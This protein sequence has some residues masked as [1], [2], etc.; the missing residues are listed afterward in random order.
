MSIPLI[1]KNK[2]NIQPKQ[3]SNAIPQTV[4]TPTEPDKT[5]Q[6]IVLEKITPTKTSGITFQTNE[7]KSN[8]I[9]QEDIVLMEMNEMSQ[10]TEDIK[11]IV[12]P[13]SSIN[14]K[15]LLQKRKQ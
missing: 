6:E 11:E 10:K 7:I 1:E 2:G 9:S 13:E 12:L 3:V 8:A 5:G 4:I 14:R 15:V